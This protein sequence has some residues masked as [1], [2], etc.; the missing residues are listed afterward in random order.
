MGHHEGRFRAMLSHAGFLNTESFYLE[1]EE[2]FFANWDI[3]GAPWEKDN[4]VAQRTFAESPHNFI[5]RWATPLMVTHGVLDYR[6]LYT[7]SMMAFNAAQLRGIPSRMLIFP[8]EN[9]WIL[10]PQN[11]VLFHREFTRWFDEW[12]K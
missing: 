10:R 2:M 5:Y 7:Q 6:V 11:S 4:A 9:H 1:T 12:L 3:G 8:D